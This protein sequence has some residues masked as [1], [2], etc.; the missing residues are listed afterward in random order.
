V[1]VRV[2]KLERK[3][4]WA[5]V[6]AASILKPVLVP[7]TSREWA[8]GEKLPATGGCV[9]ALNHISHVDPLLA[10]HFVYDHGRLPRY[11]AKSALFRNRALGA[12]MRGAG[13]IPVERMSAGAVGAYDAAVRAVRD[14]ECVIF[15]PEG[16]ITREPDLWPMIGKTGVARVA[17]ETG[18]P[19]IPIGQWGAHELLPPYTARPRLLP[20]KRIQ[21]LVG[22]PVDLTDL[23]ED[24]VTAERLRQAT[25]R[26]MDAITGLVAELR[27]A[28]PPVER[29]DPRRAGT[30]QVGNPRKRRRSV[31][32]PE[33]A[34]GGAT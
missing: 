2:R 4:G 1:P 29:F 24:P 7:T 19:V 16:T 33:D 27:G 17:L 3:R 32:A 10:A 22:D 23:G 11:L 6:L 28:T 14:G 34:P 30:R 25:D 8:D 12:F 21:M 9:V 5:F 26:I 31:D 15:Y 20:R 18:C 13:Q